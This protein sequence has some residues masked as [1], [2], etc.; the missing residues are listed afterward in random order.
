MS[1]EE[2]SSLADIYQV[3]SDDATT[4]QAS[5]ILQFLWRDLTSSFDIVGPYFTGSDT[6]KSKFVLSCVLETVKLFKLHGLD[7]LVI[8]CDG[9]T[10]NLATLKATHGHSGCYGMNKSKFDGF[11]CNG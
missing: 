4:Q 5:Y 1:H 10:T 6:L 7:T 9:A 11:F 3:L 2:L 8:M